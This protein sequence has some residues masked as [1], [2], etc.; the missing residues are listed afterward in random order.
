MGKHAIRDEDFLH[1]NV[2]RSRR[3]LFFIRSY[4]DSFRYCPS[5]REIGTSVGITSTSL[6]A[7]YVTNLTEAGYLSNTRGITR[8][9][10]VS[11]KGMEFLKE[12]KGALG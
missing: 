6:I 3:I 7:Y 2:D 1:R 5:F 9:T 12:W 11:E 4:T 10:H 8:S